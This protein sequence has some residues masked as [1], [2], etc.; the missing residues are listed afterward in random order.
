M[1]I[2]LEWDLAADEPVAGFNIYRLREGGDDERIINRDG[3]IPEAVRRFDDTDFESGKSY[4]YSL[5]VV[6]VDGGEV[7]SPSVK[8]ETS[9]FEFSLDRIHPNPFNLTTT[10]TYFLHRSGRVSLRIYDS[11]GRLINTLVSRQNRAG[12]HAASWNG[13]NTL[14]SSVASG[15]YF[16]RLQ[17]GGRVQTK[18]IVFFK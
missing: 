2:H 18:K 16:V 17:S 3:L 12:V 13:M 7:R 8:V 4:F 15:V 14:G 9:P 10:I 11:Q 6:K 1:V 5:G